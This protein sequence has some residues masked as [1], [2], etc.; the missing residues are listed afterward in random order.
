MFYDES[1][2]NVGDSRPEPVPSPYVTVDLRDASDDVSQSGC[3]EMDLCYQYGDDSTTECEDSARNSTS[4]PSPVPLYSGHLMPFN[5]LHL[6]VKH[7]EQLRAEDDVKISRAEFASLY[8]GGSVSA[9]LASLASVVAAS[10][11]GKVAVDAKL[12]ADHAL[13]AIR[14]PKTG[15]NPLPDVLLDAKP[16]FLLSSHPV[17]ELVVLNWTTRQ[18]FYCGPTWSGGYHVLNSEALV[19]ML[20][21]V[22]RADMDKRPRWWELHY[23]PFYTASSDAPTAMMVMQIVVA[24]ASGADLSSPAV[25]GRHMYEILSK[26]VSM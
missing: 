24:L 1:E 7:H 18:A 17:W 4:I 19:N 2:Y 12:V 9:T 3:D 10:V 16:T 13:P 25:L 15:W 6:K 23:A 14:D 8:H 5:F 26:Y 20:L 22:G 21:G 11:Y